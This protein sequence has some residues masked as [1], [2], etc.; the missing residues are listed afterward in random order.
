MLLHFEDVILAKVRTYRVFYSR[1]AAQKAAN[2]NLCMCCMITTH[3]LYV[4]HDNYSRI[5][6][7]A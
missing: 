7:V 4:L 2:V 1:K 5:V 3:V 6:C